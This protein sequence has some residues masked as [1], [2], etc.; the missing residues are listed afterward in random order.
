M[1]WFFQRPIVEFSLENQ[2]AVQAKAKRQ[3]NATL[4]GGSKKGKPVKEVAERVE[5]PKDVKPGLPSHLGPK[6]RLCNVT[7]QNNMLHN[8]HVGTPIT[9]R[10]SAQRYFDRSDADPCIP[11]SADIRSGGKVISSLSTILNWP[12]RYDIRKEVRVMKRNVKLRNGRKSER[13]RSLRRMRRNGSNS[14]HLR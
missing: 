7:D 13:R 11:A 8:W 6:V 10:P 14:L 3:A 9:Q 2:R 12:C 1:V 4:K 5:R